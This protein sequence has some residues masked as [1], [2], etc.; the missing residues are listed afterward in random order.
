MRLVTLV[1]ASFI[2]AAA[3]DSLFDCYPGTNGGRYCCLKNHHVCEKQRGGGI[4]A[5]YSDETVYCGGCGADCCTYDPNAELVEDD[6][7][8]GSRYTTSTSLVGT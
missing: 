4:T 8:S 6:S 3:A 7:E 5:C 2:A 1:F